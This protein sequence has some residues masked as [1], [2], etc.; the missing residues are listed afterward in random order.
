MRRCLFCIAPGKR[1]PEALSYLLV[2]SWLLFLA[3]LSAGGLY[4][5]Q[6]TAIP[7]T[8]LAVQNGA[9]QLIGSYGKSQ[10]LRL[11]LVLRPPHLEEEEQ[12]LSEVQDVGSPLFHKYLTHEEWNA[13]FAPSVQDEQLVAEWAQSQGLAITQRYSNRL[14]VDVEAPAAVIEKAFDVHLNS[15][16][17]RNQVYFSNDRDPSIPAQLAG[18]LQ[19]ILGLNNLNVV[20]HAS[21]KLLQE[22]ELIPPDYSAGPAYSVGRVLRGDGVSGALNELI[23]ESTKSE[24]PLYGDPYSPA[25]LYSSYAYNYS[26][27]RNLGHCC[28]PLNNPGSSPPESSI[29]IAIWYDFADSDFSGFIAN[30]PYLAHNVQRYHINGHPQ[31]CDGEVTLDVEWATATSNNFSSASGTAK[32]NVYEAPSGTASNMLDVMNH[33]LSDGH[34]RV[35]TMSWGGSENYGFYVAD[36]DSFHAV[37]NQLAGEGWT[38]VAAAGDAG[39]TGD[40]SNHLAVDYPAS[41]P[42]ITAVGGTTLET[43]SN[44]FQSEVTWTGGWQGCI[45]NDGGTGGGCSKHYRAPGY[46]GHTA[47]GSGSRSVPDIALNA[48]W[49]NSPQYIYYDG[50][51]FPDGGTSISAP[52]FAGFLAQEN[53]YLLY[54]QNIVGHTCGTSGTTACAPMGPAN[55]YLYQEGLNQPFAAHYPFYDITTGC[56]SNDATDQFGL[57]PYC[58]TP[59]F[60]Q[61]TGWGTANML[62]LAWSINTSLAGDFGPPVVSFSGAQANHW[63]NTNQLVTFVISDT[64]VNGHRPNGIA[65]FSALWDADPG[66]VYA[67]PTPGSGNAFYSGPQT[68]N[69]STGSLHLAAAGLGCHTVNVRAWDNAGQPNSDA[70]YGPVC[71]DTV[72]PVSSIALAG[73]LLGTYYV[74]QVQVTLTAADDLSGVAATYYQVDTGAWQTYAGPFSVTA[75]GP[76]V[77]NFYSVDVAGNSET[78]KTA[79]FVVIGTTRNTLTISRTGSG[80]G[81][82]A[83]VDGSINCGP[84][85][86]FSYFDGTPVTL[87]PT[88]NP[89]SVFSGWSGCDG[90]PGYNCYVVVLGDRTATVTF[91]HAAPLQFVAVDPCRVVDTRN[92]TGQFGGPS[93]QGGV[94]RSFPIPQGNC[95][96][97]ASAAAYSF[98]VT[99]VPHGSL[100]YL[101]VWP[102]GQAQP[103]VS[104]VN[105]LDGRIKANAAIVPSGAAQAVSVYASQ[106]TDV[107]LDIDGYF[108]APGSSTLA[109]FAMSPCRVL[110]TRQPN[111]PLGG[112]SL[113]ARQERDFPILSSN[114]NIPSSAVA[115]SFNVTAVPNGVLSFLTLW[116]EGQSRPLVSTLNAPTGTVT[117]NAAIVKA[118]TNGAIAVYPTNDTNLVVDINGYFAPANSGSNPLSLYALIP[119]RALDTRQTSGE[120]S[121][122]IHVSMNNSP[123]RLTSAANA[124][125]LNATVVPQASLAYLTL[126]PTG[127]NQPL[128]STLNALDGAITSNMAI[129]LGGTGAGA[130]SI[131]AYA[132]NLTQLVLDISGYFGP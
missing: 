118:G 88:P 120:F 43:S 113:V 129:V 27:L 1:Q 70:T 12:F 36:M 91:N 83:S 87:V 61:V 89:G 34:A 51:L 2:A 33:I 35:L 74:T 38:I 55:P 92:P 122:A 37:F 124:Y 17:L 97:P 95:T 60:D 72:P 132:S 98:N 5:E 8:P 126:W 6:K 30:Y 28:N 54:V 128:T 82:V 110:D 102:T 76:H 78:P 46:Q 25:D 58:A 85:C 104:T 67:E 4:G 103:V 39:A 94:E 125:V 73:Q 14:L 18:T 15:Y 11:V 63:Y 108:V 13:R 112:P 86:S 41:D 7:Q 26:G 117:A 3:L 16:Q 90:T 79:N 47:C 62:Q 56:N 99:V 29:A 105:S 77:F 40:C 93:I 123:C 107:I 109:L 116:P 101:T 84:T 21:K 20:H 75:L 64:T 48:D 23:E 19:T 127:Q 59:G 49:L 24:R 10:M 96:I 44:L 80:T 111:G 100:S 66:D 69:Q 50:S 106:T 52:M 65:G 130:G 68:P 131:D 119:C 81:S 114:C 32:V 121:G 31:C 71:Y 42:N 9:A 53:A 45:Y 115:Y 22:R 57:T